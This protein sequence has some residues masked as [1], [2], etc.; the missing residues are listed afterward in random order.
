VLVECY[1]DDNKFS[2]VNARPP[3]IDARGEKLKWEQRVLA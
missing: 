3:S 2:G 1:Q